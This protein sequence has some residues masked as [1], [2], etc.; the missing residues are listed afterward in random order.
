[1]FVW[2]PDGISCIEAKKKRLVA[3]Q[4]ILS[5]TL[6]GLKASQANMINNAGFGLDA[7]EVTKYVQNVQ[8]VLTF[9]VQHANPI[10]PLFIV[11]GIQ[12]IKIW[13]D[14]RQDSVIC[15]LGSTDQIYRANIIISVKE[16]SLSVYISDNNSLYN[17]KLPEQVGSSTNLRIVWNLNS[18]IFG[19]LQQS[20]TY[21]DLNIN[22]PRFAWIIKMANNTRIAS[23]GTV[24]TLKQIFDTI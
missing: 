17:I 15:K 5:Q 24:G 12:G 9:D 7:A 4:F 1:M 20:N 21:F 18:F 22:I 13:A 16:S 8:D 11:Q 2:K 10:E 23:I 14:I 6:T 19:T 3:L